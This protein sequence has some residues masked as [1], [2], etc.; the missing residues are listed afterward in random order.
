[1]DWMEPALRNSGEQTSRK[2]SR[3]VLETSAD[4]DTSISARAET[5]KHKTLL[6]NTQTLVEWYLNNKHYSH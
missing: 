1:M 6:V 3:T 5:Q 2:Q 4:K